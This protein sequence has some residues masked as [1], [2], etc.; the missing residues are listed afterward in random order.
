[1][2]IPF[3]AQNKEREFLQL[4][5]NGCEVIKA[6][7]QQTLFVSATNNNTIWNHN[8][9]FFFPNDRCSLFT[10]HV[11]TLHFSRLF[12][13][14][15]SYFQRMMSG[16]A[17]WYASLPLPSR[18]CKKVSYIVVATDNKLEEKGGGGRMVVSKNGNHVCM[19][20]PCPRDGGEKGGVCRRIQRGRRV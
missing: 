9:D 5:L 16:N 6:W 3:L 1:M 14:K 8:T 7:F 4:A 11:V 19:A 10:A 15:K 13:S 12:T 2:M 17:V 20:P 18:C